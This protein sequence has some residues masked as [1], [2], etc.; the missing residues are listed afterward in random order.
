M[1]ITSQLTT[2]FYIFASRTSQLI[3]EGH[4]GLEELKVA[5][6]HGELKVL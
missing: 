1:H 4:Q 5:L 2:L 3:S 6:R